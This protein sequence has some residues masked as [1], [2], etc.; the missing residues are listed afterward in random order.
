MR[1]SDRLAFLLLASILV[2]FLAASAA[3]TPLYPVYQARWGFSPIMVTVVFASYAVAVLAALLV[4]GSLSDFVGR[5]P[6]LLAAIALQ[7][8]AMAIFARAGG[9]PALLA[10][11]V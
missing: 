3:P 11:R 9:L 4:T 6:V 2:G 1:L 7:L 8:G 10:A 5:R